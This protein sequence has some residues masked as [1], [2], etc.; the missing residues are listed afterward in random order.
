M[1]Q[2]AMEESL[3]DVG[4]VLPPDQNNGEVVHWMGRKPVS[5]GAVGISATAAGAFAL[6]VA[7]TLVVLA[8]SDIVD[9]LVTVRRRRTASEI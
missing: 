6:G 1:G 8:F 2:D 9:P 5:V 7:A 4:P 3:E